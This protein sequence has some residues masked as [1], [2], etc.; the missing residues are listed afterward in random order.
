MTRTTLIVICLALFACGP[1]G[2]MPGGRLSGESAPAPTDW[3]FSD[4]QKNVQLETRS[5][6]PYSV[7]VWG[8]G[9][10]DH[11]YLAAGRGDESKWARYIVEDPRVRLRV[12]GTVYE[13]AAV[14]VED[15]AE[16]E[17]FLAALKAKYD[18]EPE[19]DETEGAWLFRLDPR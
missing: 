9:I 15:E 6:D 17:R 11:F 12:A 10:G 13:M 8:V 3:S 7:N 19:D 16:R 4:E 14:R 18:W 5:D 1:M 2:P